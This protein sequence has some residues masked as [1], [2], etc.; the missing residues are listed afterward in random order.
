[1]AKWERYVMKVGYTPLALKDL[2]HMEIFKR[3]MFVYLLEKKVEEIKDIKYLGKENY[4]LKDP[5]HRIA[6]IGSEKIFCTYD[7]NSNTLV[8]LRIL[9]ASDIK[10][11][12]PEHCKYRYIELTNYGNV[13][14]IYNDEAGRGKI[15][16]EIKRIIKHNSLYKKIVNWLLWAKENDEFIDPDGRFRVKVVYKER[17]EKENGKQGES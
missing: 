1:M 4:Y 8:I 17:K 7:N 13:T 11:R 15:A 3:N 16:E 14:E 10:W 12:K 2:L 6:Y 9:G 5:H